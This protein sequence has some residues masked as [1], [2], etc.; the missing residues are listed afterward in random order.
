MKIRHLLLV[1]AIPLMLTSCPY[2]DQ[3]KTFN[4]TL[5]T[6]EED[7]NKRIDET[8]KTFATAMQNAVLA[9]PGAEWGQL[10]RDAN[11]DNPQKRDD[12]L[13]YIKNVMHIDLDSSYVATVWFDN[14]PQD[15]PLELFLVRTETP[16]INDITLQYLRNNVVERKTIHGSAVTSR[17]TAEVRDALAKRLEDALTRICGNGRKVDFN[18][19]DYTNGRL[20]AKMMTTIHWDSPLMQSP[21][22]AWEGTVSP[23]S[24]Q[25][26]PVSSSQQT[27]FFEQFIK[28]SL[29]ERKALATEL[30]NCI[31]EPY[32]N[33]TPGLQPPTATTEWTVTDTRQYLTIL[34][35]QD[36]FNKVK[37]TL[38]IEA[39]VHK[40]DDPTAMVHRT[41]RIPIDANDFEPKAN[42][43][44]ID[45]HKTNEP[46]K[47]VW[48]SVNMTDFQGYNAA[49][50]Q[51]IEDI[52]KNIEQWRNL[53]VTI[54]K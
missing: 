38:K 22:V 52:K 30:A 39:V 28:G 3:L 5:K 34:L 7:L 12:A 9:I 44:L 18:G 33:L 51:E 16:T 13:K 24:Q 54:S 4:D 46:Q 8:R 31:I 41:A 53:S 50:E 25:L 26:F 47:Y 19:F 45:L 35:N 20:T 43:P 17:T 32:A 37:G 27:M 2:D 21:Y 40:K 1:I 42:N 14:F 48:Y 23:L 29:A 15:V 10:I 49:K 6:T 11:G 36:H